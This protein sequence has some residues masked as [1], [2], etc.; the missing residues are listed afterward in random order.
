VQL[1]F[2]DAD[3]TLW[4]TNSVYA[5]AQLR[6]LEDVESYVGKQFQSK[7]RLGFVRAI[8]QTIAGKHPSGL[9]YPAILLTAALIREAIGEHPDGFGAISRE[10]E[11]YE[12][13]RQFE[14]DLVARVR[15][16]IPE[17]REGVAEALHEL[18]ATGTRIV[19]FTEGDEARC[20]SLLQHHRIAEFISDLKS[21]RKSVDEYLKMGSNSYESI[22]MVGDQLD[23]DIAFAKSAGFTTIYFPSG[24]AP[25]WT[26]GLANEADFTIKT[27]RQI[28][29]LL[30]SK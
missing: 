27:Y 2:S 13:A 23:V 21:A 8:D 15:G 16:N 17:L 14:Q 29:S 25:E 4:D 11:H 5:Q 9:R 10:D 1:L 19:V 26:E 24:F 28:P 6:L 18:S 20:R 12:V 3:N 22:F 7:D 30:R